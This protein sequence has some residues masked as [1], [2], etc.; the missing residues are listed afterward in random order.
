M[1]SHDLATLA[2]AQ[3][4]TER[5]MRR[6]LREE[7]GLDVAGQAFICNLH[8]HFVEQLPESLRIVTGHDSETSVTMPRACS[9]TYRRRRRRARLTLVSSITV[10]G[11]FSIHRHRL[12]LASGCM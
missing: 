2:V 3:I 10:R 8:R 9:A 11:R 5:L 4:Q 7:P 6:Q 12:K 1:E